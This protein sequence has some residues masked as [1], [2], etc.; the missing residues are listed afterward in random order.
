M[1]MTTLARAEPVAPEWGVSRA[2]RV[3]LSN[4]A[5]VLLYFAAN[6]THTGDA[7]ADAL[8]LTERTVY[9]LLARLAARG[10][11]SRRHEGRG[12]W[13]RVTAPNGMLTALQAIAGV[14]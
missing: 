13:P 5:L 8:G 1:T 3:F 7:C 12:S 6:P 10:W 11:L 9:K 4:E 14:Q 2:G